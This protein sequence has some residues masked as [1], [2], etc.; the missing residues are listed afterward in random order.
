MR[1]W[2]TEGVVLK[3]RD[4]KEADKLLT[5]YTPEGKVSAIAKGVRKLKSK[6]R[7]GIQL[8][9]HSQFVLYRGRSLATVTQCEVLHPFT[10]LRNDLNRFAY[11]AYMAE[12]TTELVPEG[13][14]NKELF[15]LLLTCL[16]LLQ[17]YPPGL[18]TRLFEIR[19]INLLG[20]APE[21]ERCLSCGREVQDKIQ[22]SLDQ[23]GILCPHCGKGQKLSV[24]ISR[25]A[26][27]SL[28]ALGSMDLDKC[29]RLKLSAAHE[30]ELSVLLGRYIELRLEK[31]LRTREF[32]SLMNNSAE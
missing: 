24:N 23:G 19:I 27:A 3:N 20:Y 16:H 7:G 2:K 32:L 8:F 1:Y 30:R 29:C 26:L 25:G 21:L 4:Y 22:F 15:Y 10:A 12:L 18:V 6:M 13:E 11:A 28:K 5:I 17:N 31:P 9:T 14:P